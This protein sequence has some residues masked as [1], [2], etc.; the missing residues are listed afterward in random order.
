MALGS[1]WRGN[2]PA[3]T[4]THRCAVRLTGAKAN[5]SPTAISTR[6]ERPGHGGSDDCQI[7]MALGEKSRIKNKKQYF[8]TRC[9]DG[10]LRA[11]NFPQRSPP[12][13]PEARPDIQLDTLFPEDGKNFLIEGIFSRKRPS[14]RK[15]LTG[16]FSLR[17]KG[18]GLEERPGVPWGGEV[19]EP[20]ESCEHP[21]PLNGFVRVQSLPVAAEQKL[22][23]PSLAAG[24]GGFFTCVFKG[25]R[26]ILK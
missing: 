20:E 10:C 17:G 2:F 6:I 24:G 15:I 13:V 23:F 26:C 11:V 14:A 7:D 1:G 19:V 16:R 9:D 12:R 3:T 21:P 18:P 8:L 25:N 5:E 22:D 4:L